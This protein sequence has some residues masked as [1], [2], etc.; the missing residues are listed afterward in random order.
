MSSR[1]FLRSR[2]VAAVA[3]PVLVASTF[4]VTVVA[5]SGLKASDVAPDAAVEA[6]DEQT[7]PIT[8]DGSVPDGGQQDG[9][10]GDAGA[11]P[12]DFE[13]PT[14]PWTKTTKLK[15]ECEARQV[16]VIE[17]PAPLDVRG[18]LIART[19]AGRVGIVYNASQ[20]AETDEMHL[21]HFTP[22]M[23]TYPPPKLV[24]RSTGFASHD[25]YA[26]K[27]AAMAP[28]TLQVLSYDMDDNTFTGEVHL[29]KLV[30]GAE[31][32]TDALV[33][34]GV[35]A[36]TEIAFG[37]DLAGNTVAAYRVSTGATTAKLS[38]K[39]GTPAG[40]FTALPDLGATLHPQDAPGVGAGSM[41]V[42]ASGQVHFL[43]QYND[44]AIAP[45]FTTPRYH[46]L[47]GNV[48]SDRKTI[49]NNAPDGLSGFSASL[50]VFGTKK[51]AAVFFHK[52]GQAGAKTADLLLVSWDALVDVPKTEIIDTQIPSTDPLY[53]AYRVAIAVDKFGLVH[54]AIIRPTDDI[55]G[56]GPK[57]GFLEYRRQTRE[58]GGGTKWLSDIVDPA[59]FVST[60]PGSQAHVAMVVDDNARPHIAYR[61]GND[62][63]VRYATR[64]DR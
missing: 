25:G 57:N 20:G 32:L 7:T 63:S 53:P 34:S 41:F 61:S 31:P 48:W 19:P 40:V 22:S 18:I 28:D 8:E 47:A 6:G 58:P 52:A 10:M 60:N 1:I 42:E 15:K 24:V 27:I 64:F 3:L 36:P 13:C 17:N 30:A 55:L 11:A 29:R 49:H 43:Y 50:A 4:A 14:D 62:D 2:T 33:A 54:L 12:L 44:D 38:S 37:S 51:Y 59:V 26:T 16:K 23:P 56:M 45:Q 39:Q 9:A 5:C 35:K 46:T 21:V